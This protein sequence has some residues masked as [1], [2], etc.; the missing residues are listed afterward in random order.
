MFSKKT[1]RMNIRMYL[2]GM[3]QLLLIILNLPVAGQ[4]S[5]LE[6]LNR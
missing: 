6:F 1:V 4:G 5:I 3:S 2:M